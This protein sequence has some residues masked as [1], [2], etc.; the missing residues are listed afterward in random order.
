MFTPFTVSELT[1]D[2]LN[3]A[4]YSLPLGIVASVNFETTVTTSGTTELIARYTN[5][6]AL[7]GR[8]YRLEF[9]AVGQGTVDTDAIRVRLRYEA[10]ASALTASGTAFL[11][12]DVNGFVRA[13]PHFWTA[14]VTGLTAQAYA[15]GITLQ[16]TSGT[17]TFSFNGSATSQQRLEIYDVGPG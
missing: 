4:F 17:G 15:I 7:A 6:T 16:R 14:T 12:R 1:A 10:T 5:F 9:G 2:E 11:T 3:A 13:N 8:R